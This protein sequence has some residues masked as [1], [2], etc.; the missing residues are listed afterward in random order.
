MWLRQIARG[1]NASNVC[2]NIVG[3]TSA[4]GTDAINNPL[5]LARAT[6]VRSLLQREVTG[7]ERRLR[8]AGVGKSK[9]IIGTG[10]DDSSDAVDRRV[11]FEVQD[12][13]Q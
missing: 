5:S 2:L 1:A 8:V 6:A 12:C 10:A 13:G 4:S 9:N 7:L 3:H 11:E